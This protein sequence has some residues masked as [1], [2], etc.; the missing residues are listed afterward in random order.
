MILAFGTSLKVHCKFF[1]YPGFWHFVSHA[2]TL[3]TAASFIATEEQRV[4]LH[5]NLPKSHSES[6]NREDRVKN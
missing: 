1:D 3:S 6:R 4:S 2:V 5:T